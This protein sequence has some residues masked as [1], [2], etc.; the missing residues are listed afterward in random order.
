MFVF[1][2]GAAERIVLPKGIISLSAE[3]AGAAGAA[4]D[5]CTN[6]TCSKGNAGGRGGKLF[7]KN[8]ESLFKGGEEL[9]VLVGGTPPAA[10]GSTNQPVAGSGGGFSALLSGADPAA[11][12]TVWYAAAGGGGGGAGSVC[13]LSGV[14]LGSSATG[15]GGCASDLIT[16]GSSSLSRGAFHGASVAFGFTRGFE[17]MNFMGQ[18]GDNMVDDG[19]WFAADPAQANT[20]RVAPTVPA[21]VVHGGRGGSCMATVVNDRRMQPIALAGSNAGNGYVKLVIVASG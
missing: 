18:K 11:A 13:L 7:V 1:N 12:S 5:R 20:T 21:Q 14:C 19:S 4:G 16:V 10:A 17:S 2:S 3:V 6:G 8:L 15:E 9:Y